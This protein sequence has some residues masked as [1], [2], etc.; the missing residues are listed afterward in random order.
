MGDALTARQ[1]F[2]ELERQEHQAVK[3]MRA[4]LTWAI[5]TEDPLT[6]YNVGLD[7][8]RILETEQV[9]GCEDTAAL[10]SEL[11]WVMQAAKRR[12]QGEL[13]AFEAFR[14]R[15]QSAKKEAVEQN[16][17]EQK[18]QE[19][20]AEHEVVKQEK[21]ARR[22]DRN[23]EKVEVSKKKEKYEVAAKKKAGGA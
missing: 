18:A 13:T 5:S 14:G 19:K 16:T 2:S 12:A 7:I 9:E 20:V 3:K 23:Q 10:A 6:I 4:V 22:T 21:R 11:S 1:K 17:V 15:N 8:Y